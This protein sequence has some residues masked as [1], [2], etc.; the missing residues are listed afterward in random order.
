MMPLTSS[1]E[2]PAYGV[3]NWVCRTSSNI[4]KHTYDT[5][6]SNKE[7]LSPGGNFTING[8]T[9]ADTTSDSDWAFA[10][11]KWRKMQTTTTSETGWANFVHQYK[12]M[13]NKNYDSQWRKI[14]G[15]S[16]ISGAALTIS[17]SRNRGASDVLEQ[18]FHAAHQE[19]DGMP[20][21]SVND[22]KQNNK[23]QRRNRFL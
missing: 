22:I 19:T 6:Q 2:D 8:A 4:Q 17:Q 15:D 1:I 13:P 9:S 14:D 10:V 16:T 3:G 11:P 21:Q 20:Y 18:E 5:Q 7:N 23:N 12:E